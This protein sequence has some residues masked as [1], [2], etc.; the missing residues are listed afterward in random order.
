MRHPGRFVASDV[1]TRADLVQIVSK[2]T[3]L[4]RIGKQY[5]GRCPF[6]SERHPSFYV[7]PE[8]KLFHCFGCGAGGDVFSFVMQILGCDFRRALET[9]ALYS[10]GVAH[11]SDPRSGSRF[12]VGE[13]GNP[14]RLTKAAVSHSQSNKDSRARILAELDA[15]DR[16]LAG[17]QAAN[18]AASAALATACEPLRSEK[19]LPLFIKNRITLLEEDNHGSRE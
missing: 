12:G 11:A 16:R 6:H 1:K 4:R 15:T 7:H 14:L 13:G 9:V 17:I 2:Y 3:S 19:A 18:D 10:D 5:V 8:R